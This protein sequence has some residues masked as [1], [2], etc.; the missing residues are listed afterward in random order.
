MIEAAQWEEVKDLFCLILTTP[1]ENWSEVLNSGSH[2]EA[3]RVQVAKLLKGQ[4][5]AGEF[6]S[7][8]PWHELLA[9]TS[10]RPEFDG[11]FAGTPRF[12]VQEKLGEGTF[13]IV[14]RALD[15]ERNSTVAL[16]TLRRLAPDHLLRFK[17]E[18]RSLV[19]L[20][21]PNLVQLYELFGDDKV[22]FYTMELVE[23]GRDFLSYTRPANE[24]IDWDRIRDA[25]TQLSL[26]VQ[27]LHS[28]ARVHRDLKPSNVMVSKSGQVLILDFGLVKE[29][30]GMSAEQSIALAGSPAYMAPE[31]VGMGSITAAADWYA[32]GVMLFRAIT[33]E[34]PFE[35]NSQEMIN[36]KLARDAP[37]PRMLNPDVPEDLN[38]I[39]R[40]LLCRSPELRA[41][42]GAI[43]RR[44][45]GRPLLDTT[46]SPLKKLEPFVGRSDELNL[47][48]R[49]FQS[50]SSGERQVVLLRGRSGI[51]KTSLVSEFLSKVAIDQPDAVILR[52]RC[53]ESESVPYKALDSVA[54]QLVHYLRGLPE[55]TAAALSPRHPAL[56]LQVFP[57][58]KQLTT[59]SRFA[60]R[61]NDLKDD[62]EIRKRAFSAFSEL[63]GRIADHRFVVISIDDLQ[64]GDLDSV[65][66][67]TELIVPEHAPNLMLV[68]SFRS[69]DADS[70]APVGLLQSCQAR[71]ANLNCWTD[72]ELT[73][74]T[75]EDS[76]NLLRRLDED[77]ELEEDQLQEMVQESLGS[78]LFL[79]ELVRVALQDDT[80]SEMGPRPVR[81]SAREMILRRA[82]ALSPVARQLFEAL[83]VAVEPLTRALLYRIVKASDGEVERHVGMLV[84]ENL[85]RVTGG[86]EGGRLEP[87]HDQV[88]EAILASMLPSELKNWHR[89]LALSFEAEA[90]P[91]PQKLLKHYMGAGDMEAACSSALA[92]AKI[93]EKALAFD[94]AAG[95]YTT[96]IETGQADARRLALIYKQ[97]A[98]AL[99]KAGRGR[100][101]S[102]D[103]LAASLSPE[104]NDS[105]QMR[106]LAAEQLMRSGNLDEG[107]K[108]FTELL[109]SV[110]FWMPATPLQSILA[111][112]VLRAFIQLRGMQWRR[113]EES[114]LPAITLRNLDLLWSGASVFFVV[115]PV[116]G[117]YLQAR[118]MLGALNAGEPLRLALSVGQGA[119]FE[120]LGGVPYYLAGRNFL[121]FAEDIAS[122]LQNPYLTSVLS[123]DW[124]YFDILCFRIEDGL[125]HSRIAIRKLNELGTGQTWESSTA[126]LGLIWFLAWAGRIREMSELAPGLLDEARSRGDVYTFV[127]IRCCALTHLADLAADN[128]D[129]ALQEISNALG[130]WSQARYDTPHFATA[131]ASVECELYAGRIDQARSRLLK[132]WPALKASLLFRK[133]QTFRIMLLYM[134]ARTALAAWLTQ[135]DDS[136][137][138]KEVNSCVSLLLKSRSPWATALGHALQSSIAYGTGHVDEAIRLLGVAETKLRQQSFF[139]MAAAVSRRR[140]DL[141]GEAG[142]ARVLAADRF[143]ASEGIIRPD[144][145]AFMILPG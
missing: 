17:H 104:Y 58:F 86:P 50:L 46:A 88:R 129:R 8:P 44:V 61:A 95:F 33:G 31:Q 22:W 10:P 107:V 39:C 2:S 78:P 25:L 127:I 68:L 3:V 13:G 108:A 84:H 67:L 73:G 64:W 124:V 74:L 29:L 110:G 71:V 12:I 43:F 115:N 116:F 11:S 97:R 41:D 135:R 87:Y 145:M 133:C 137:L 83:A 138:S 91:D 69:E 118:H 132:E 98:E 52:G 70:S 93:S 106:R 66:L 136:V 120:A 55:A 142:Y 128:P 30:S 111:M 16:K 60:G 130:Q 21:H 85:V 112:L 123:V 28:S 7:S 37:N 57:C 18:F 72:I 49:C 6:L 35:G 96:A 48:H 62:Q 125:A 19:D 40:D 5:K 38:E 117:T 109:S 126:K 53:R 9:F 80:L 47:L 36:R 94:Q 144:R 32:V 101:A 15:R 45:A 79:R 114:E 89:L 99:S 121:E 100:E 134:R 26:G 56:L 51:G 105:F 4:K 140:G 59:I 141:E 143:M 76:C 122:D 81:I 82:N 113:R 27:A 75:E 34:F 54:D 65:A 103:Y 92:A 24:A 139:L 14:Y 102:D 42:G 90:Y 1:V 131:F 119:P 20:V 77:R 63:V 23:N